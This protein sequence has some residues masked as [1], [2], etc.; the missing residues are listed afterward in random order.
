MTEKSESSPSRI[1]RAATAAVAS[2]IARGEAGAEV[3]RD[4]GEVGKP[5]LLAEARKARRQHLRLGGVAG[6]ERR[7]Q[8]AEPV[9]E[10]EDHFLD[11]FAAPLVAE[12]L[13]QDDDPGHV[14]FGVLARRDL[15]KLRTHV[16]VPPSPERNLLPIRKG[17]L[18]AD[19][20]GA[21]PSYPKCRASLAKSTRSGQGC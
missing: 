20:G 19:G 15:I 1:S 5:D 12:R 16:L 6:L 2:A 8:Q 3:A 10:V 21:V 9:G 17:M 11:D 14:Q 13:A 18:D 4:P 7:L